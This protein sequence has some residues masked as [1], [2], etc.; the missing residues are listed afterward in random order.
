MFILA[1]ISYM[2]ILECHILAGGAWNRFRHICTPVCQSQ[3][4]SRSCVFLPTMD[5]KLISTG[6]VLLYVMNSCHSTQ[7]N[8]NFS[9]AQLTTKFSVKYVETEGLWIRFFKILSYKT[10]LLLF[11]SGG[12]T[13][14]NQIPHPF[15]GW[16]LDWIMW[17]A[18]VSHVG[19]CGIS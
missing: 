13:P 11:N 18:L 8:P 7:I 12:P 2:Y 17:L 1:D 5:G 4:S 9:E 16:Q 15:S 6:N 3:R 19:Y 14:V 10:L